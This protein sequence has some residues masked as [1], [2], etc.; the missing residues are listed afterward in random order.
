MKANF[1]LFTTLISISIGCNK[2]S[3]NKNQS[4]CKVTTIVPSSGSPINYHYNTKGKIETIKT[5]TTTV[6]II[7]NGDSIIA[8][9]TINNGSF[10]QKRKY[11][12]NNKG[13]P[14]AIRIESDESGANWTNYSYEYNGIELR[15]MT[16]TTS[17]ANISIN[18]VYYWSNGNL[19]STTD[20]SNTYKYDYY[21]DKS[22][23][24]GDANYLKAMLHDDGVEMTRT[25]NI[26]K[27]VR[28]TS[29]AGGAFTNNYIYTY[30]NYGKITAL[31][32]GNTTYELEYQCN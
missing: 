20:G 22:Y 12:I 17:A 13:F 18:M 25:K 16:A 1:L 26:R 30:D 27:S 2:K 28:Y 19:D 11:K 15:K 9:E 6:S 7:Y 10:Y 32:D 8:T 23:Q 5:G 3:I 14:S 21:T 29:S 4:N 31:S 24:T